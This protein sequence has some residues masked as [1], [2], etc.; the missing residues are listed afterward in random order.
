MKTALLLLLAASCVGIAIGVQSTRPAATPAAPVLSCRE[1]ARAMV[2]LEMLFG[3]SRADA[4]PVTDEDWTS[5]LNA[6]V[7][8]R[9]PAGLTTLRGSGQWRGS[10]G[11]LA[12]E[13]THVLVIWHESSR[14]ADADIEAI[15]SAYKIRFQQESVMRVDS[16]SCV[17]L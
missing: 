14:R 2:R 1:P 16:V 6:E 9:F 15:R 4:P 3:T 8:P 17:S 7:T 13:Q 5:F 11:R 12:K 10:D